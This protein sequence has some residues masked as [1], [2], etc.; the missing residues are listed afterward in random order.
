MLY[1]LQGY[2]SS[3]VNDAYWRLSP[4]AYKKECQANNKN[5]HITPISIIHLNYVLKYSDTFII[6]KHNF[7][8]LSIL[9]C[10]QI[11]H[12][13][14]DKVNQHVHIVPFCSRNKIICKWHKYLNEVNSF[15]HYKQLGFSSLKNHSTFHFILLLCSSNL[16]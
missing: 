16:H 9:K 2:L 11:S 5:Q 8:L 15:L 13:Y 7:E 14:S 3:N 10:K 12:N 6:T 1:K 4:S